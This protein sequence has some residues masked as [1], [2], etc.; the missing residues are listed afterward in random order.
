MKFNV[1]TT[2][3]KPLN[4][5]LSKINLFQ[6]NARLY[7]VN[8]IVSGISMGVFRLLFN[9]YILSLGF[10]EVLI[11]RLITTSSL[12]A[13]IVALPMGYL[14]DV[15]G[16]KRSLLIGGLLTGL[17]IIGMVLWPTVFV[18]YALN[19]VMGFS[20][21]LWS[22]TMSPFLMENSSEKERTYLFSFG[23]G[24][25]MLS[26]FAGNWL[27][28][29]LPSMIG[30][31]LSISSTD[32]TSYGW[33]IAIVASMF[34]VGLIPLILLR[35]NR[36]GGDTR[37][38]FAPINYAKEHPKL[39]AKLVGPMLITS[40]GAGLVMPFMN[41]FFRTV[42]HQP[43]QTIGTIFAW[44]SLAMGLGLLIAPV[45]AERFGKIQMVVITQGLSVPFLILL[46]FSPLFWMSA[47]AYYVRLTLM[48]MSSP[49]YETFVM[50]KVEPSSRAMVA[51]L[52][53]MAWSFG[54]TFSPSISGALQVRYGFSLPFIGTIS[55]YIIAIV[56]YWVFFWRN[57]NPKK[58]QDALSQAV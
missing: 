38:V 25:H 17:S 3:I 22:I 50:E 23:Y 42:H 8:V 18:F 51:A 36:L 34:L 14:A 40:L 58:G 48:N 26:G 21:S 41:V 44:G 1:Q 43:D 52:V 27:G 13:L 29:Y 24:L 28:G 4:D 33:S 37:S 20:Q 32:S 15:I 53:S 56:L 54:W 39:L 6:Y 9:F 46:G 35:R 2:V 47:A 7:L 10:N 30:N 5:Y 45:L 55:M 49:I 57:Q 16:R 11:G 31:Q 12:T 19:V